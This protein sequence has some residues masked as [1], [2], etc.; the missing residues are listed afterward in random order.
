MAFGSNSHEISTQEIM[1][2]VDTH[3][4]A[5]VSIVERQKDLEGKVE[6]TGDKIEMLDHNIIKEL[7]SINQ[8]IKH[9]R[10]EIHDLKHEMEMIKEFESKVKRQFKIVTTKDEVQRLE[11][12][13]D[14][15]NPMQFATKSELLDI[16]DDI[17]THI[18]QEIEKFL[19]EDESIANSSSSKN[20]KK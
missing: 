3:S 5:L 6:I 19:H 8:D 11:R 7:R 16:R 20:S 1:T 12:Y 2:K 4:K 17:I 15:W 18:T 9:L 13:I 14:L 10:D